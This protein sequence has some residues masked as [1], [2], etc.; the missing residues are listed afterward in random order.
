[1]EAPKERRPY[2]HYHNAVYMKFPQHEAGSRPTLP[3]VEP[4]ALISN[5]GVYI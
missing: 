3:P 4:T 2:D 1:M 5:K